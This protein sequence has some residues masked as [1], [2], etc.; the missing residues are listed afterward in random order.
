MTT[1]P[2]GQAVGVRAGPGSAE[3]NKGR[4]DALNKVTYTTSQIMGRR[5][6]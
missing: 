3:W 4:E 2:R 1:D 6:K 5:R